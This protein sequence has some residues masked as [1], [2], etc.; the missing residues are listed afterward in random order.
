MLIPYFFSDLDAEL[1]AELRQNETA[2]PASESPSEKVIYPDPEIELD[3]YESPSFTNNPFAEPNAFQNQEFMELLTNLQQQQS[4][5][6]MGTNP[7]DIV[8]Q[9]MMADNLFGGGVARPASTS[10]INEQ[11]ETKVTKL[12]KSKIHIGLLAILTYTF[13]SLGYS[14]NVFLIFLIWEMVEMFILK[15]YENKSGGILSI[16]FMLS[17]IS[18]AKLN[19]FFKWF[20]IINRVLRDVAIFLFFFVVSHICCGGNSTPDAVAVPIKVENTIDDELFADE[21]EF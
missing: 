14:C 9:M 7:N 11:P 12:L 18:P 15:Q 16:L 20:Q 1:P 19:V 4:N 2:S 8:T 13:I 10:R 3:V 17:G 6:G 21:F 5:S